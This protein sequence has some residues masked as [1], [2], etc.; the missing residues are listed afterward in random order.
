MG[1]KDD[2]LGIMISTF[3][4]GEF[5]FGLSLSNE[6]LEQ[7]NKA[8]K[9]QQYVDIRA[10][11]EIKKNAEGLQ[12]DLMESPFVKEFEY[13]ASNDGYWTYQHVV[14][15]LED[16]IDVLKVLF[17]LYTFLFRFDHFCGHDKQRKVV[18]H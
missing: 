8:C 7:V 5:A 14:L 3:Q 18:E 12:P 6:Q 15:Q 2:G 4:S 11:I 13:G 17:P 10:A 1:P 9:G 16:C